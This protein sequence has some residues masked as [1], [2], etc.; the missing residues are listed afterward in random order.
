ERLVGRSESLPAVAGEAAVAKAWADFLREYESVAATGGDLD[1]LIGCYAAADA[2]NALYRTLEAKLAS[3]QPLR[4][5]VAT[6]V[7]LAL[8]QADEATFRAFLDADPALA[9]VAFYLEDARR[10]ARLRLPKDQERLASELDVD[11]F[12]AW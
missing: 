2:E 9:A 4:S 12:S 5:A 1:S 6:N 3:F 8:G 10:L 7:E 11:G